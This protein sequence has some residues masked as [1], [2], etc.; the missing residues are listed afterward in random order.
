MVQWTP[1]A[2]V[3]ELSKR[4]AENMSR[5]VLVALSAV[6]VAQP[7]AQNAR[8]VIDMVCGA[9]TPQCMPPLHHTCLA[10]QRTCVVPHVSHYNVY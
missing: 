8:V 4:M 1:I 9:V 5:W 10:M 2:D 7:G 6:V 3:V